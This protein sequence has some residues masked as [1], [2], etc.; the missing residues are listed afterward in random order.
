MVAKIAYLYLT[1]RDPKLLRKF[2]EHSP[3]A[4]VFV[5]VDAKVSAVPFIE[6]CS[7]CENV[8]FAAR[9]IPT[10]WGDFSYV[11]AEIKLMR[12]ALSHPCNYDRFII[13]QGADY[14]IVSERSI[15]RYFEQ[16]K[17]INYVNAAGCVKCGPI[18]MNK[19]R[20]KHDL[21]RNGVLQKALRKCSLLLVNLFG[22][23]LWSK[24]PYVPL[25]DGRKLDLFSGWAQLSVTR[26]AANY[27]VTFHDRH[28]EFNEYFK[29]VYAADESY[30]HTIFWNSSLRNSSDQLDSLTER[31]EREMLNNTYFEYP[32]LVRE[33]SKADEYP[34]LV[35]TGKLFFRKIDSKNGASL[36]ERIEQECADAN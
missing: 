30:F 14:P 29:T 4:G 5:H 23:G 22:F 25:S 6:A 17:A 18:E 28:P 12:L 33:F 36:L 15:E 34:F 32:M 35:S 9:R 21:S 10:Y 8:H 20:M 7:D 16:N 31:N 19:Y 13:V 2:A 27:F 3:R 26:D 11:E 1:H 24:P